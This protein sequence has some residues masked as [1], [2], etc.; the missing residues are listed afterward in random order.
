MLL[1]KKFLNMESLKRYG[2]A[3]VVLALLFLLSFGAGDRGNGLL[4][5]WI[6]FFVLAA[7]LAIFSN[8]PLFGP[9]AERGLRLSYF[10]PLLVFLLFASI[11][12]FYVD[13]FGAFASCLL[14]FVGLFS[15]FLVGYFLRNSKV[16]KPKYLFL[17]I[18]LGLALLVSVNLIANLA[19][20]PLF[21]PLTHSSYVYFYE[22]IPHR[23]GNESNY[24]YNFTLTLAK[25]DVAV[26][27]AAVLAS[28]AASLFYWKK[29]NKAEL[30]VSALTSAIGWL[31]L[32]SMVDVKGICLS[33]LAIL[34]LVLYRYLRVK[35]EPGK[36]PT[37]A[38]WT[39][40]GLGL[41]FLF[42]VILNGAFEF[43]FISSSPLL[44]A[45]F[46]SGRFS[47]INKTVS[48][49][50]HGGSYAGASTGDVILS[51]LFGVYHDSYTV[52]GGGSPLPITEV[53]NFSFEF[54]ILLEGGFVP[55]VAMIILIL[56]S[57]GSVRRYLI[58]GK[59]DAG[60]A[61]L[62]ALVLG[63]F[64]FYTFG[65]DALPFAVNRF[66]ASSYF[67]PL[68][69]SFWPLVLL[70]ILGY[71]YTPGQE[72]KKVMEEEVKA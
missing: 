32:L 58:R 47:S 71:T 14:L 72:E 64:F 39:V 51:I 53:F 60:K 7:G 44:D 52:F 12:R 28:G 30:A 55:F 63:V 4:V 43:S 31:F 25:P 13:S 26:G 48:A 70:L 21:Y 1:V 49:L 40:I 33:L 24:L 69:N 46:N 22:G 41:L 16:F 10:I 29:E 23:I 66:T 20:Y 36:V 62:V 34:I 27:P 42:L 35:E 65:Y 19:S 15:S 3:I 37:I 2:V 57:I 5:Y 45:I 61:G 38:F 17:A 54:E 68:F 18:L 9:K 8:G 67:S 59:D 6:L 50:F 56:Y 11:N